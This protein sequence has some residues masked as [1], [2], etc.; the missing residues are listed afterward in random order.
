MTVCGVPRVTQSAIHELDVILINAQ[1]RDGYALL[2]VQMTVPDY[3]LCRVA[4]T[5]RNDEPS[6]T[7]TP[8]L[9]PAATPK[10]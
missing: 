10:P 4:T 8:R 9:V 3:C 2:L 7:K 1:D 5:P 6:L